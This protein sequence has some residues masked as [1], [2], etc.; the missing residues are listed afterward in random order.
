MK[1]NVFCA[2]KNHIP[3]GKNVKIF[4]FA[5]GQDGSGDPPPDCE[6]LVFILMASPYI[7]VCLNLA[8]QPTTIPWHPDE[9]LHINL[10]DHFDS[11]KDLFSSLRHHVVVAGEMDHTTLWPKWGKSISRKPCP[12]SLPFRLLPTLPF[13]LQCCNHRHLHHHHH[14]HLN[15]PS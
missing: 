4:T 10:N 12:R 7:V 1:W 13:P 5:Y 3:R 15:H 11:A 6:I 14:H 9:A 2:S 8:L